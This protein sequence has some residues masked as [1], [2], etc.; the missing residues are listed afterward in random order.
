[1]RKTKK[2]VSLVALMLVTALATAFG[3][4]SA[5]A[6][7]AGPEQP[8]ADN[9]YRLED[10]FTVATQE[11]ISVSDDATAENA[12]VQAQYL[13]TRTGDGGMH[14]QISTDFSTRDLTEGYLVYKLVAGENYGF[15]TLA[16]D[17]N[18]KRIANYAGTGTVAV[19]AY[20]SDSL[21]GEYVAIGDVTTADGNALTSL[22]Y[23]F[24]SFAA[25]KAVVYAKF[26]ISYDN[27]VPAYGHDWTQIRTLTFRGEKE[28][29]PVAVDDVSFDYTSYASGA[30]MYDCEECTLILKKADDHDTVYLQTSTESTIK[31]GYV[32]YKL[33]AKNGGEFVTM[34]L[35]MTGRFMHA[36]SA[37]TGFT[38]YKAE[39]KVDDGEYSVVKEESYTGN[40]DD[41]VSEVEV[42]LTDKVAGANT[43]YVKVTL[44]DGT[45]VTYAHDWIR[46]TGM[47]FS[48]TEKFEPIPEN[49]YTVTYGTGADEVGKTPSD[50]KIY[51]ENDTVV[52]AQSGYVRTGYE[53][54]G[55]LC[56]ADNEVYA[57]GSEYTMPAG[58]V[59][60]TA[61]WK[62]IDY[63]VSYS[64]GLEEGLYEGTLPENAV[65]H[66]GDEIV[67][68]E[69]PL[70]ASGYRFEGWTVHH[71][72][73]SAG[74]RYVVGAENVEIGMKWFA[75]NYE[76]NAID[77]SDKKYDYMGEFAASFRMADET[78]ALSVAYE[79]YNVIKRTADDGS[80]TNA[81]L[82]QGDST[83]YGFFTYKLL[84]GENKEFGDLL[85]K[86]SGRVAVYLS[87]EY[88]AKVDILA[89]DD[90]LSW[91]TIRTF[92]ATGNPA[93]DY[94]ADL[95]GFARGKNTVYVK[96]AYHLNNFPGF[97]AEWV[98]IT[99]VEISG[100]AEEAAKNV[101]VS[102][103]D[104]ETLLETA[105]VPAGRYTAKEAPAKE[106]F[107]FEGWYTDAAL[108][109]KYTDGTE[110]KED[111][112]LY[113]KYTPFGE[114]SKEESVTG[115]ES[116]K[117]NGCLGSVSGIGGAVALA[118]L[119][120][121]RMVAK[122]REESNK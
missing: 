50:N 24:T 71:I 92:E 69:N 79:V 97:G 118:G 61:S 75:E 19:S 73:Y 57:A 11:T 44:T 65:A 83:S 38:S 105:V 78:D 28:L 98:A 111:L 4:A 46:L 15:K 22:S 108:T 7:D 115:G 107:V 96:I 62:A 34:D 26:Q 54:A 110:V 76:G 89:S 81:Q 67:F 93:G 116:G 95:S 37:A 53:F 63:V 112:S 17:V 66:I 8:A 48:M 12:I 80:T 117:K 43:V 90:Y 86:F 56:S 109:A 51:K 18:A 85:L 121:L 29:I 52:L 119:A 30:T 113:A 103:Y 58:N 25:G 20:A 87:S 70:S 45:N 41:P 84:A 32:I 21:G 122:K 60:F 64:A 36:I 3:L 49:G 59:T 39:V 106:G 5:F 16:L 91:T 40:E 33:V 104:G 27:A 10:D 55:W 94:S 101:T 120:I 47:T 14:L 31:S 9:V 13:T 102:Y 1:M 23:D 99:A 74:D 88:S 6:A 82:P 114:E 68:P 2:I 35:K 42:S 77:L 100:V 72:L